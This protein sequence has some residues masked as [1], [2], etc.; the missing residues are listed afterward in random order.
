[1][2]GYCSRRDV[3]HF[4]T[5]PALIALA[6]RGLS[7]THCGKEYCE[8]RVGRRHACGRPSPLRDPM[9]AQRRWL[10]TVEAWMW[11]RISCVGTACPSRG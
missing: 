10:A 3:L 4:V 2:T 9:A 1:M 5:G 8:G 7:A 6:W 11:P